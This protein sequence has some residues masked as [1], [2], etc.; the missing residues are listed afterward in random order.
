MLKV[1][2]VLL[3][4]GP[5]ATKNFC[6]PVIGH[7]VAVF[8]R[9]NRVGGRCA[10]LEKGSYSWDLGPTFLIYKEILEDCFKQVR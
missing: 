6:L 1:V 3:V 7:Q 10:K 9:S 4:Q 5:E 2:W 8:E